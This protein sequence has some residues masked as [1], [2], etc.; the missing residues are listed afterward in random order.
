MS[1]PTKNEIISALTWTYDNQTE[2][3]NGLGVLKQPLTISYSL[4]S[5]LP[6]YY[7]TPSSSLDADRQAAKLLDEIIDQNSVSYLEFGQYFALQKIIDAWKQYA[8]ITFEKLN[9]NTPSAH[10]VIADA[11]FKTDDYGITAIDRRVNSPALRPLS[12]AANN[13]WGDIWL[14]DTGPAGT[15]NLTQIQPGQ[16]GY[17]TIL[18]EFGHALG[19]KHPFEDGNELTSNDSQL[20]TIMSYTAYK[21]IPSGWYPSKPMLY[22]ILAIQTLYGVNSITNIGNDS[23]TFTPFCLQ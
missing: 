17:E 5:Y 4:F 2:S 21:E 22:D 15:I 20:Y 6:T 8:N 18:H 7:T 11:S 10:I 13:M 9:D 12:E 16:D 1:E 14:N 19:L 23:Y 3:W